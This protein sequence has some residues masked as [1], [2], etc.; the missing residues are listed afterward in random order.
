MTDFSNIQLSFEE[1]PRAE[2]IN[3]L[4]LDNK[5]L[6]VLLTNV[7]IFFIVIVAILVY[8]WTII[9]KSWFTNNFQWFLLGVLLIFVINFAY[10]FKA[11]GYKG[12][13][14][15]QRD[16]SYKT[17]WLWRSVTTVPFN[18]VQHCEVSQGIF[19][20]YFKLAKLKI[21]TAGGSSSDVVVP[22]LELDQATELKDFILEKIKE[23]E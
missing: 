5:Y 18:R 16:I 3:Y 10:L 11:F 12:Y 7:F 19:D 8:L 21:Y 1:I 17:G 4:P 9:D 15:R 2:K 20:R 6:Y 13:A 14:F 23:D 22:G